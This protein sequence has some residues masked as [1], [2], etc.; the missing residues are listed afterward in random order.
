MVIRTNKLSECVIH[1]NPYKD[2]VV[3]DK[4]WQDFAQFHELKVCDDI[5]LKVIAD[6]FKMT[7]FDRI[8]SFQTVLTCSNHNNP[9]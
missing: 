7:I 3:L 8:T 5:M 1:A 6:G 9:N 4:G 2:E